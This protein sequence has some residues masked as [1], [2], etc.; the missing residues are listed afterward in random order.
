MMRRDDRA[1]DY[2]VHTSV[3]DG[4]CS[5]RSC[6]P[7][8]IRKAIAREA[9]KAEPRTALITGLERELRRRAKEKAAKKAARVGR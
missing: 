3:D 1:A 7:A 6:S 9:A 5:A 8:A 2:I 4:L